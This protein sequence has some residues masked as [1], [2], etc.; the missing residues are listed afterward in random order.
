M[1]AAS[2]DQPRDC[3][4][5]TDFEHVASR[6]R[7]P[8][9][10]VVLQAFLRRRLDVDGPMSIAPVSGGQSNPTYF[11]TY[12]DRRLVLRKKPTGELLP[13]AHAVDREYRVQ[14]ALAGT[15]VPVAR[16]LLFHPDHDVVGT[17]FYVMEH[18]E[19]RIFPDSALASAP[20]GERRAMYRSAARTLAAI[21]AVD[22]DR[23]GL[24]DFGRAGNYIERQIAR[25]S[26]QWELSRIDGIP[27]VDRLIRWL[28]DNRPADAGET[29]LVHGDFRIGNLIF[30]PQAPEVVAVL[31]WELS[32]LGDPL[33]DLAHSCVYGWH[34][35][36]GEYGGLL[37]LDL[38]AEG[39]PALEEFVAEYQAAA[40]PERR[41]T[42]FHLAFALFRNAVIFAGIAARARD[43][44]ASADNAAEIGAL[45][46]TFARRGLELIEQQE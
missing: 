29:S 28:Q 39:L 3:L 11:L 35:R 37:G 41:M 31:D 18:V 44:N 8:F 22:V 2:S 9:D 36:P 16:M 14:A 4:M 23:S 46:P 42:R 12:P 26:R 1:S 34:I 24:S 43:G 40:G 13:S 6:E 19:G 5:A 45:A 25:W 32:T 17:P 30:H 7:L 20:A 15:G 21:H 10:P 27:E 33:A 38:K